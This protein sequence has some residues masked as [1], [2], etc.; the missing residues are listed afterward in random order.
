MRRQGK[1]SE[2]EFEKARTTIVAA[3]QRA[4][5]RDREA[6][7]KLAAHSGEDGRGSGDGHGAVRDDRTPS[8]RL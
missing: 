3:A 5:A 7:K 4:M 6:A 2:A 1:I 8:G